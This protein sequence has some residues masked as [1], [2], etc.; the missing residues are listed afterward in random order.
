MTLGLWQDTNM[1]KAGLLLPQYKMPLHPKIA[2][3]SVKMRYTVYSSLLQ[4]NIVVV[5]GASLRG[6]Q[7]LDLSVL[8][9]V[10]FFSHWDFPFETPNQY[11]CPGWSRIL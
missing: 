8:P 7:S 10:S 5:T 9:P 2:I 1:Y 11:L 3:T 6:R 4:V